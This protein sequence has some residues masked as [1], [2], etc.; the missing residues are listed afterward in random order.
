MSAR[1]QIHDF[2][3][4][5]GDDVVEQLWRYLP[6]II[7][8]IKSRQHERIE[9]AIDTATLEAAEAFDR[10]RERDAQA[11]L[12]R[13]EARMKAGHGGEGHE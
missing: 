5:H 7:R 11:A 9:R 3:G 8:A 13:A 10:R 12:D 1:D 2:L 4:E 6:G